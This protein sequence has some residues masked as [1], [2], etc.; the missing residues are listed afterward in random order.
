M[1]NVVSWPSR[2]WSATRDTVARCHLKRRALLVLTSLTLFSLTAF[3]A[4]TIVFGP[5]TYSGNGRPRLNTRRR[6]VADPSGTFVLRVRNRGVTRAFIALNGR[7]VLR[8]RDFRVGIHQRPALT[9]ARTEAAT[10]V[11]G[12]TGSDEPWEPEWDRLR[13][14]DPTD[15]EED[16][17]RRFVPIIVREVTMRA[18]INDVVIGFRSRRGTSL[19]VEIAGKDPGGDTTP[20]TITATASPAPN[21][22]GWNNTPV[23][24]TFSCADTG[25]GIATCPPPVVVSDDGAGQ[26]VSGKAVDR[27]G[28][29]AAANVTINLDQRPPL[30]SPS[31]SP[32]ANENGWNNSP[33]TAHFE[34]VDALS[35][36]S[37]CPPDQTVASDG[38]NQRVTGQ[39]TD[40]AG[41]VASV[42]SA[43]VNVDTT[44]PTIVVT[45]SPEPGPG[46]VVT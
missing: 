2:K 35:G 11:I 37:Q 12:P 36:V 23:T 28:N 9:P 24:V 38:A 25:S 6:R 22:G 4:D 33:V 3:S 34:C 5:R 27:A 8:P 44:P 1:F 29:S 46:G 10:R 16:Q 39:A 17:D 15:S 40:G 43:P 7:V 13:L 42:T 32:A 19:T 20:P 45:L 41:N 26:I 18:G 31:L 14:D 21:A 30:V